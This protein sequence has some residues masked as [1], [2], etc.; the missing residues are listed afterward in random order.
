MLFRSLAV[1]W[2][3]AIVWA[4]PLTARSGLITWIG[5][6]ALGMVLRH[7]VFSDGTATAFVIVAAVFLG[8][9]LNGWRAVVR[10]RLAPAS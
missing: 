5:T 8:A 1:T 9:V 2:L 7:F 4:R 3:V 6:V 10:R